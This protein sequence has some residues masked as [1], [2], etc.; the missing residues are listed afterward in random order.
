M[1]D[2]R[3]AAEWVDEH[4]AGG[5]AFASSAHEMTDFYHYFGYRPSIDLT[6]V[7]P[8]AESEVYPTLRSLGAVTDSRISSDM[9]VFVGWQ[10]VSNDV[11]KTFDGRPYELAQ[12]GRLS[13]LHVLPSVTND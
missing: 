2:A 12:F 5:G 13:V 8:P 4:L 6:L 1:G 9:Y 7:A 3:A 10:G 11:F